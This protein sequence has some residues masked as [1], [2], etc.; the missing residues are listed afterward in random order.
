[1]KTQKEH[2][3]CCNS[4]ILVVPKY[5]SYDMED[6]STIKICGKCKKRI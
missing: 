1:M 3:K 6:T 4:T 5:Q 2:S